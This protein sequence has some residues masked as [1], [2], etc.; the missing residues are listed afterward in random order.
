MEIDGALR[1]LRS[2]IR[3][4]VTDTQC[5]SNLLLPWSTSP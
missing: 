1:R 5:H 4:F 2:E 3:S